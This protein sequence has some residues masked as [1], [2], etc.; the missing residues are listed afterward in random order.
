VTQ[1]GVAPATHIARILASAHWQNGKKNN[2]SRQL[3]DE[4]SGEASWPHA[5]RRRGDRRSGVLR[6]LL[7]GNLSP[8]RRLP[9]RDGE[10]AVTAVDWHHP[11]WL[12]VAVIILAFSC[13]DAF[14]TLML[15]ERGAYEANP[16]M[17]PLVA[18]SALRFA[19]VKFLLT[20]FGV[21]LLTQ[22]ARLRAFG[23]VPVGLLL[24]TLLALY[25]ALIV[26]ELRLLSAV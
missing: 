21:V 20:A 26:H 1:A 5:E 2:V 17:A 19:V 22:L 25:G 8:R 4:A 7:R 12:A 18:G 16:L 3:E 11:Q 15:L 24:Y 23:I 13:A 10:R 6:G 14:L 9:R